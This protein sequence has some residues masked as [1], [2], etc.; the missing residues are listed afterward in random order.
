MPGTLTL[1][2]ADDTDTTAL[3]VPAARL[4]KV[5]R[6]E[7]TNRSNTDIRVRGWDTFTDTA[8]T[9]HSSAVNPVRVFDYNVASLDAIAVEVEK[10]IL[11]TLVLQAD[12]ANIA[13]ATPVVVATD[14]EWEV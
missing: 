13:E 3:V 8:G 11:G 1:I 9:V 12:G 6:I 10:R 4:F 2:T 5:K 7:I 14:G